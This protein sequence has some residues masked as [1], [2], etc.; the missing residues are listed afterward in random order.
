MA[1][2]QSAALA[3]AQRLI[4]DNGRAIVLRKLDKSAADVDKPWRGSATPDAAGGTFSEV[5]MR[6][7]SVMPNSMIEL[8]LTT[9]ARLSLTQA[10][11]ALYIV[12]PNTPHVDIVNHDEVV[13]GDK[14]Y[15]IVRVEEL[16]PA[17]LTLLYYV[18]VDG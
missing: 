9:M 6:A 8:G 15:R 3:L 4:T 17:D 18:T 5:T 10:A 16:R 1:I 12:A 2:D 14:V 13:D 11:S 7:V